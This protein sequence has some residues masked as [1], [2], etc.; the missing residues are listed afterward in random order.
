MELKTYA[1]GVAYNNTMEW[2]HVEKLHVTADLIV[3]FGVV[4]A[5]LC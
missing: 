2:S 1:I 4:L 3:W 5:L